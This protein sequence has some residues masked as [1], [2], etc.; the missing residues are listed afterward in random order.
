MGGFGGYSGFDA[1]K[2]AAR[3]T[4][5]GTM[6]KNEL[7]ERYKKAKDLG[8]GAEFKKGYGEGASEL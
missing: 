3:Q 8:Q 6:D 5:H 4:A 2:D 7:N 1:G